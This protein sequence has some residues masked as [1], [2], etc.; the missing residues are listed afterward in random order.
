MN[1]KHF[2]LVEEAQKFLNENYEMELGVPIEFNTRL[3]RCLGKFRYKRSG[4]KSIPW[5]IEMSV[6]FMKVHPKEHI[7]DVL[8]HELVHYALCAKGYTE[9][10]FSDGHFVFES[11]LKK[12]GVSRTHTYGV[13]GKMHHYSCD[14][15]GTEWK[16]QRRI[17]ATARCTCSIH[18]RIIYHGEVEFDHEGKEVASMAKEEN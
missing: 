14:K 8:R 12:L 15:C 7:L 3:K 10:Q 6:E 11:E 1:V 18:S 2:E 16:R 5:K 4:G 13:Y 17:A 9:A